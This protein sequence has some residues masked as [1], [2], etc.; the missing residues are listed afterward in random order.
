MDGDAL[1]FASGDTFALA[2][3][4][5][6]F[7]PPDEPNRLAYW[8]DTLAVDDEDDEDDAVDFLFGSVVWVAADAD[9]DIDDDG[10][11][12]LVD[13]LDDDDPMELLLP[14]PGSC[15]CC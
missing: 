12:D 4:E 7:P 9:D 13:L 15:W 1:L 10:V 14:S 5:D 8:A 3:D 6:D 2:D 11:D